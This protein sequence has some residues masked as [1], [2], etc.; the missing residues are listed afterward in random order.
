MLEHNIAQ[1]A[2]QSSSQIRRHPGAGWQRE[3]RWDINKES[4][5]EAEKDKSE[6]D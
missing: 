6:K 5:T 1:E 2:Q 3:G 4:I